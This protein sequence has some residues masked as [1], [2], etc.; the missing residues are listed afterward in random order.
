MRRGRLI[1]EI[2]SLAPNAKCN[3]QCYYC[4]WSIHAEADSFYILV[5]ILIR[6][7]RNNLIILWESLKRFS[8]KYSIL[9]AVTY[10]ESEYDFKIEVIFCLLLSID[11]LTHSLFWSFLSFIKD[12]SISFLFECKGKRRNT[13]IFD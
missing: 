7:S 1:R 9:N 12:F 8:S 4:A 2:A 13:F 5:N 6:N 3:S 10:S 11:F